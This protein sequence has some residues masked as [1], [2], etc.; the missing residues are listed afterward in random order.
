VNA[1]AAPGARNAGRQTVSTVVGRIVMPWNN[2]VVMRG[3]RHRGCVAAAL[4][5]LLGVANAA[6]YKVAVSGTETDV[7]Y[8]GPCEAPAGCTTTLTLDGTHLFVTLPTAGDGEFTSGVLL[9]Y[10]S[11]H[12]LVGDSFSSEGGDALDVLVAGGAVALITGSFDTFLGQVDFT[13]S[14]F[15]AHAGQSHGSVDLDASLG[16]TSLVPEPATLPT[17]VCGLL[18]LGLVSRRGS[19]RSAR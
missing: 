2:Q 18:I 1:A 6:T 3:L 17:L 5:S 4:L 8:L 9:S 10:D 12:D 11:G 7:T 13:G 19:N 16:P 15:H 14:G